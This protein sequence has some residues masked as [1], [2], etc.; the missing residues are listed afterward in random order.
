MSSDKNFL[1]TFSTI[2][3]IIYLIFKINFFLILT[4]TFFIFALIKP[5][6]LHLLNYLVYKI[7]G[8][9]LILIQPIVLR[10]IFILV[11]GVIGLIMKLFKYDPLKLKNNNKKSF[12]LDK[13]NKIEKIEDLKNQY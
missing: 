10:I 6:A 11:F 4:L 9:F 2:T 7:G 3:L 8:L 1:L 12:W 5:N 13:N